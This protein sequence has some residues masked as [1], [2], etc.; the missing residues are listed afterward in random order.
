[1][2]NAIEIA[3]N[4]KSGKYQYYCLYNL[5]TSG[6]NKSNE[7]IR[8]YIYYNFFFR[9]TIT[10][11]L[12]F[13]NYLKKIMGVFPLVGKQLGF[14]SQFNRGIADSACTVAVKEESCN[15]AICA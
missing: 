14:E 8:C 6:I 11:Y 5:T 2:I 15:D 7:N 12:K 10:K 1:M 13:N 3:Y 4:L 9:K